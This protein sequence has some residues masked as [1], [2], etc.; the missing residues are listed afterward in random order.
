VAPNLWR[1]PRAGQWIRERREALG[2]SQDELGELLCSAVDSGLRADGHQVGRWE[3]AEHAP[4]PLNRRA[5]RDLFGTPP[6]EMA[7]RP[8]PDLRTGVP[9]PC[10]KLNPVDRRDF[11]RSAGLTGVAALLG[12]DDL[13]KLLDAVASESRAHASGAEL[14]NIGPA[15]L[16]QLHADVRRL[17]RA[18]VVEAPMPLFA[19]M[20][21]VR[22]DVFDRLEGQQRPD[23]ASE[24]HLLAGQLCCLL[25]NATLDLGHPE[26][27][28]Q[29]ARAAWAYGEIIGHDGLRAWARGM[30]SG[31]AYWSGRYREAIELASAGRLYAAAGSV[32]ARLA[33]LEAQAL[34]RVGDK[35]AA[36]RELEIAQEA[37]GRGHDELHD[38]IRG[39]FAFPAARLA[40]RSAT[41]W[42]LVG[43]RQ[44]ASDEAAR[45]I[46]LWQI[47]PE[48]E[49]SYGCE[50]LALIELATARVHLGQV[51]GAAEVLGPVLRLPSSHHIQLYGPG[52]AGLS[53]LL[54]KPA[55]RGAEAQVLMGG[56]EAFHAALPQALLA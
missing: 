3:R 17:A 29:Q 9:A 18:Y 51:E 15:A 40:A 45:A 1:T 54:A 20:V 16:D 44:R 41:I 11:L 19:E 12:P 7:I 42:N 50:A 38:G 47:S 33:T 5:L 39:E 8:A 6:W 46:Q 36:G 32:L 52:L 21:A 4:G 24:L 55:N 53:T 25:A 56:I 48:D 30:E 23:Q 14:T 13:R 34:A 22:D 31:I 35:A 28:A 10:G 37:I 26:A 2:L 49:R 27:A 43:D